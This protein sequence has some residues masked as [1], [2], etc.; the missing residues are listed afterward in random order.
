VNRVKPKPDVAATELAASTRRLSEILFAAL[1]ALSGK[2][3]VEA[4]C[5]FAGQAYMTLRK[6]D[7]LTARRFDVLLHRLTPKLKP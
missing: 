4:A 1:T 7:P 5:R 3:D 6:A 2:G